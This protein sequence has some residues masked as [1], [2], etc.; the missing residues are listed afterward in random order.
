MHFIATACSQMPSS[1]SLY[2]IVWE[3][4]PSSPEECRLSLAILRLIEDYWWRRQLCSAMSRSITRKCQWF[5]RR[6]VS[7]AFGKG[8]FMETKCREDCCDSI[9]VLKTLEVCSRGWRGLLK[10]D[11]CLYRFCSIYLSFLS[12][13]C[14]CVLSLVIAVFCCSAAMSDVQWEREYNERKHVICSFLTTKK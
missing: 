4:R 7:P 14:R 2:F 9:A 1:K 8:V 3:S 5:F 10:F 6:S 12:S 13:L 11:Q